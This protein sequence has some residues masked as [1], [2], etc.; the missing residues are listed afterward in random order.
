ML[1]MTI[2]K[3]TFIAIGALLGGLIAGL[4]I[5]RIFG[6]IAFTVLL[7]FFV[8]IWRYMKGEQSSQLGVEESH[9]ENQQIES[10]TP[11]VSVGNIPQEKT[12]KPTYYQPPK[13]VN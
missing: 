12:E 2:K 1:H 8:I 9:D 6:G 5:K 13:E 11:P 4:I 3:M 10:S 7:I